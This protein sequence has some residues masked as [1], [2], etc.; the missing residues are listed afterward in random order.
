MQVERVT[1][2][3]AKRLL[4]DGY[5]YVDVRT[6]LEY[7]AGHPVG[8][9]NVPVMC[10]VD[11][12]MAPNGMFLDVMLVTYATDAKLVVGCASGARSKNAIRQLVEAGYTG[13]V[14]VRPGFAGIRN[15]FGQVTEK[16]WAAE[17]FPTEL[18]TAGGS[19]EELKSKLAE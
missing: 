2:E 19:Y 10:R 8:A 3:E 5:T 16:G 17:G 1:A 11:G 14:D 4:D 6:E 12:R 13:L 15:A 7:A 9:K 18:V